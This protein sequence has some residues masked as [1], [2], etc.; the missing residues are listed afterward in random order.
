MLGVCPVFCTFFKCSYQISLFFI[1]NLIMMSCRLSLTLV[2]VEWF[3][4]KLRPFEFKVYTDKK[5]ICWLKYIFIGRGHWKAVLLYK[6]LTHTIYIEGTTFFVSCKSKNASGYKKETLWQ[7]MNMYKQTT[8]RF[9]KCSFHALV[10]NFKKSVYIY[11]I[12]SY[13]FYFD[14]N[15][16]HRDL[17]MWLYQRH[18]SSP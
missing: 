18:S 5:A 10:I 9:F 17:S 12:F 14:R 15:E 6:I 7:W 1:C 11:I 3:L 8:Y 4:Q 16:V 2:M 13:C